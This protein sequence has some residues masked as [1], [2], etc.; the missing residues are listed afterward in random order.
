MLEKPRNGWSYF[1]LEDKVTYRFDLSYLDD[2]AFEW[3]EQAIIGL[4]TLQ[5][6]CVKGSLEPGR[7]LCVVSFW[8]CYITVENESNKPNESTYAKG[9]HV[10]M[11][12][13][14]KRLHDDIQKNLAEWANFKCHED[15]DLEA[16]MARLQERLDCLAEL[17]A[18]REEDFAEGGNFYGGRPCRR[19][20]RQ[21]REKLMLQQQE[22]MMFSR[23]MDEL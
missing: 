10:S 18:E 4:E 23:P 3:V 8:N 15:I 7:L 22:T 5:P 6:F 1:D 17:I 19:L 21:A 12:E 16:E 11:L 9:Y 2:V 13:F 20:D 14:C